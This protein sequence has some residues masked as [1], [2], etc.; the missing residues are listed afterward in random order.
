DHSAATKVNV[1]RTRGPDSASHLRLIFHAQLAQ[2]VKQP[3]AGDEWLHELKF[4]GY[5][6][7]AFIDRTAIHLIS[8]NGNDW[9][10]RFPTLIAALRAVP[11]RQ[12][13]LD[14][15]AAVVTDDGRTRFQALQ[16]T[17]SGASKQPIT[18]FAFDLL[19]LDGEEIS[20]LPLEERKHRLQALITR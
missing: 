9:S 10:A 16:N 6:L 18:Y 1:G 7:A 2:L 14:G 11:A 3:P 4:D 12:A 17:F 19:H 20:V 13:V 5:R 15:E 8:R